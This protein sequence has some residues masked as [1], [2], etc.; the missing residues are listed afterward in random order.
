M[1]RKWRQYC[2]PEGVWYTGSVLLGEREMSPVSI[3]D[4]LEQIGSTY[5]SVAQDPS[6]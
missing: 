3:F 5:K 4:V 2:T 6:Q 1:I